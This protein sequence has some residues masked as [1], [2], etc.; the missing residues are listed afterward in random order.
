[1]LAADCPPQE[2]RLVCRALRSTTD[3]DCVPFLSA[4]PVFSSLSNFLGRIQTPLQALSMLAALLGLEDSALEGMLTVRVVTTR[5][6]TF[7]VQYS[8]A[9]AELARDAI[10]K[11]LYE[12]RA[13]HRTRFA[14]GRCCVVSYSNR[15]RLISLLPCRSLIV[16]PFSQRLSR[17]RSINPAR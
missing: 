10:V 11:S 12:V 5:G 17:S 14:Q 15:A 16:L 7:T 2:Q 13:L 1:M 9:D 3:Q 4:A 8:V 6:E